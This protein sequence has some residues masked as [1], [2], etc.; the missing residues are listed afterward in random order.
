MADAVASCIFSE[1]ILQLRTQGRVEVVSDSNVLAQCIYPEFCLG[2]VF[3]ARGNH[4]KLQVFVLYKLAS[5]DLPL[6]HLL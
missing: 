1:T 4:V 3:V 2:L 5:G 6:Y